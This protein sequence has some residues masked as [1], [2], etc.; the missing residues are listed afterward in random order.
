MEDTPKHQNF[1][2]AYTHILLVFLLNASTGKLDPE[3]PYFIGDTYRSKVA[4]LTLDQNFDFNK[5]SLVRNTFPYRTAKKYSGSDFLFESNS[6]INQI[7]KIESVSKGSIDGFV[8]VNPGEDYKV[9]NSL[10]YNNDNTEGGGAESEVSRIKGK[11]INSIVTEYLE[12]DSSIVVREDSENLRVHTSS[13][14][15]LFDGDTIQISGLS[16]H[17]N[18][19]TGAHSIGIT[20]VFSRLSDTVIQNTGVTTD[21]YV[22]IPSIVSSGSSIGIGTEDITCSQCFQ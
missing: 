4:T 3:F 2:M 1:L 6:P 18:N 15:Q 12:Y 11:E 10:I 8:I 22:T 9:G 16:T 20:S 5:S 13:I 19:L 7:T 21:I 17:V 14:H